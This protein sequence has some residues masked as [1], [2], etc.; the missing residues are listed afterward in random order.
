MVIN[1]LLAITEAKLWWEVFGYTHTHTQPMVSVI[2]KLI[3]HEMMFHIARSRN[4]LILNDIQNQLLKNECP[5]KD[6][7]LIGEWMLFLKGHLETFRFW[8]CQKERKPLVTVCIFF[9]M[10]N[11]KKYLDIDDANQNSVMERLFILDH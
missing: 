9:C 10:S 7:Y 3:A 8:S 11:R 5:R 4:I 2:V 6:K 1:A